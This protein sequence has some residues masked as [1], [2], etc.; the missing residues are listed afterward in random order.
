MLNDGGLIFIDNIMFRGYVA[1]S[2]IPKRYKTIINNLKDFITYLNNN[3][4]FVLLPYGDGV[5]IV[6]K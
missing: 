3:T 6:K 5:G 1:E 2:D 4:D